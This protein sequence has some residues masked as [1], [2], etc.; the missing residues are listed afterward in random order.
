[1]HFIY[2]LEKREWHKKKLMIVIKYMSLGLIG[3]YI[4]RGV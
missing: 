3:I 1:M 2:Y 4:Y